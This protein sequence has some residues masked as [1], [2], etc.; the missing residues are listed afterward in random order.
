MRM[1]KPI[2]SH[3]KAFLVASIAICLANAV[4]CSGTA[5][6]AFAIDPED[7]TAMSA[8]ILNHPGQGENIQEFEVPKALHKRVLDLLDG[9]SPHRSEIDWA[10]LGQLKITTEEGVREVWLFSAGEKFVFDVPYG[11][12]G[13]GGK[14]EAD[15]LKKLIHTIEEAKK[16]TEEK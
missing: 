15:N 1:M 10:V 16:A 11:S 4:G 6:A 8:A 7:V 5:E 12:D 14:Y 13:L 2:R 9:A 3:P